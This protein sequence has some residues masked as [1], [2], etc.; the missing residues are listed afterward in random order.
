MKTHE[1]SLWERDLLNQNQR[2]LTWNKPNKYC[3]T[4]HM[5]WWVITLNHVWLLG[6]PERHMWEEPN[7]TDNRGAGNLIRQTT[8]SNQKISTYAEHQP[9]V[10]SWLLLEVPPHEGF[11]PHFISTYF[12]SLPFPLS[13]N[14][15]VLDFS[16]QLGLWSLWFCY[17]MQMKSWLC[18]GLQKTPV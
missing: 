8:L 14:I 13:L 10:L 3:P 12:L 2:G 1:T 6:S 16:T 4:Q 9:A 5:A 17:K 11:F 18:A 7:Q 15:L